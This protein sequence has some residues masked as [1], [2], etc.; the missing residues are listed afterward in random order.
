MLMRVAKQLPHRP[1]ANLNLQTYVILNQSLNRE[2][3]VGGSRN[4]LPKVVKTKTNHLKPAQVGCT[5]DV[6]HHAAGLPEPI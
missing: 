2:A 3:D 6:P 1:N 5:A 4:A